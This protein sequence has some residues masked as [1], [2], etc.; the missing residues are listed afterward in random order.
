MSPIFTYAAELYATM[1]ADFELTVE[2]A[3]QAAEK[4]T[5]GAVLNR[6]GRAEGIDPYSLM[7]GPWSRVVKYGAPELVQWAEDFGRPS[8][9]QF[10]REWFAA[11]LGE[12]LPEAEE[13]EPSK[14]YRAVFPNGD[15]W[16]ESSDADQVRAMSVGQNVTVQ[17]RYDRPHASEWR[18]MVMFQHKADC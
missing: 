9:T 11:W 2:A 15:V 4:Q 18:D 5:G 10:E 14:W 8:V 12:P 7:T 6:Q 13:F 1:R 3:Y 17:R 16:C